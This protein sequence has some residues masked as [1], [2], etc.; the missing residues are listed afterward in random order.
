MLLPQKLC[1]YDKN[2]LREFIPICFFTK[3][4]NE[5]IILLVNPKI[6]ILD[7]LICTKF[8]HKLVSMGCKTNI[9]FLLSCKIL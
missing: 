2:S 3:S 9:K 5:Y 8:I 6:Q 7:F 4:R 1:A